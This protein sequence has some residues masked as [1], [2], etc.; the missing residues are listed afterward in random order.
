MGF[1]SDKWRE[2][3]SEYEADCI[4]IDAIGEVFDKAV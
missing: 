1:D 2:I 4:I 3:R